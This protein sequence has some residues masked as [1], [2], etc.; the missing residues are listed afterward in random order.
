MILVLQRAA[1][2]PIIEIAF[3]NGK[4]WSLPAP[5]SQQL[6][7]K[8]IANEQNI[9]Y[10][11]D[12]GD[13]HTGSRSPEGEETSINRYSLDFNSMEQTNMDNN[14]KRSFCI[15]WMSPQQIEARWNGQILE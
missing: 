13:P 15:V 2:T 3:R 11:W 6:Y 5:M 4:W 8:Y 1:Y 9:G 7:D 12:W 14:R 10:T